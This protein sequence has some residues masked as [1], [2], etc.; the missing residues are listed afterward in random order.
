MR[1]RS[2]L[3]VVASGPIKFADGPADDFLREELLNDVYLASAV[4]V[5]ADRLVL[6]K[7]PRGCCVMRVTSERGAEIVMFDHLAGDQRVSFWMN[8]SSVRDLGDHLRKLP[9]V[10]WSAL[11][12]EALL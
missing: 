6:A 10:A 8:K 5:N 3:D 1:V 11:I 4:A 12:V 9:R 7:T 2:P